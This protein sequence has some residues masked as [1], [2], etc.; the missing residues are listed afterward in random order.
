MISRK[1]RAAMRADMESAPTGAQFGPNNI[2]RW[3]VH[4]VIK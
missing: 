3:C 2:L 4:I 1:T